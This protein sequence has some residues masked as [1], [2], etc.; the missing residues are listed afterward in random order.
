MKL[1]LP[2]SRILSGLVAGLL[3]MSSAAWADDVADLRKVLSTF[4][5]GKAVPKE[6]QYV[7][8]VEP[9]KLVGAVGDLSVDVS[10]LNGVVDTV[11]VQLPNKD[12][13]QFWIPVLSRYCGPVKQMKDDRSRY[14]KDP[15]FDILFKDCVLLSS[16]TSKG[17]TFLQVGIED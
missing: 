9:G 11:T 12:R 8:E 16:A 4:R 15:G 5:V 14:S 7:V 10:A 2:N 6:Q 1:G 17:F 13:G 3:L